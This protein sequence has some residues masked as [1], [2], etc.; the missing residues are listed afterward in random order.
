MACLC[1]EAVNLN[2]YL[3]YFNRDLSAAAPSEGN[4]SQGNNCLPSLPSCPAATTEQTMPPRCDTCRADGARMRCT[5]CSELFFCN[6]ECLRR[7]WHLH[8]KVCGAPRR[9]VRIEMAIERM[10]AKYEPDPPVPKTASCYICLEEGNVVRN[11]ACRGD[12]GCVHVKCLVELIERNPQKEDVTHFH[13]PVCHQAY[14]GR[15]SMV[16]ARIMWQ[17]ARDTDHPDCHATTMISGHLNGVGEIEAASSLCG[18]IRGP[19]SSITDRLLHAQKHIN[20]GRYHEAIECADRVAEDGDD[21]M[22]NPVAVVKVR[23]LWSLGE[24]DRAERVA[25]N[26]VEQTALC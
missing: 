5:K 8:K 20:S 13:C 10:L 4:K 3:S 1:L 2:S 17:R 23:A 24:V 21:C 11:C 14:A 12:A 19:L 25:K 9:Y 26:A 7:S 16:L 18:D 22:G 6:R 15:L